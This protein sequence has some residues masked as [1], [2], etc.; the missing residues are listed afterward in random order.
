ML[1]LYDQ[2]RRRI[3]LV[4]FFAL[5]VV[6]TAGVAV[7]CA[8]RHLPGQ[9]RA[10]AERLGRELG[11]DVAL[12]GLRHPRPDVLRYEG[13]TLS[14][15]ETGQSV[16]RCRVLEAAWTTT[17]DAEGRQRPALV[18]AAPRM[19][20]EAAGADRL[21]QRLGRTLQGAAG[22]PEVEVRFSVGEVTLSAGGASHRLAGVEGGIGVLPHGIQA[23]AAFRPAGAA[24]PQPVRVRVVRNRLVAPPANGFELDTGGNEVSCGV[25]SI[26]LAELRSLGPGSRFSGT[27]RA[28]QTAAGWEGELAGQLAGLALDRLV[29]DHFPHKLSGTAEVSIGRARFCGGRLEEAVGTVKA[30]PGEISRSLLDAAAANLRLAR[31]AVE[32]ASGDPV[33]FDQLAIGFSLDARGLRLEGR[34]A[35]LEPGTILVAGGS[36]LLGGAAPEPQPVAALIRTLAP[37]GGIQVPVTGETQWLVRHLPVPDILP[38]TAILP[39][40]PR[41]RSAIEGATPPSY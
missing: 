8:A 5:C 4:A 38:P 36:R 10:E 25:L 29:T 30:G 33:P 41:A 7:W 13:L 21:W 35:G 37:A 12:E 28:Y 15:P 17:A 27:L 24:S 11:F 23:Q 6:P 20:I 19:E 9:A 31:P 3:C 18:L 32:T 40:L 39:S 22:R 14:D 26:A 16:L 1:R 34:G 2:T